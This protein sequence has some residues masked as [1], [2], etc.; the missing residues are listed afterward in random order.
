MF[1]RL[2]T[3]NMPLLLPFYREHH[4]TI[5]DNT[6]GAVYQWRNA[7][8]TYFSIV[9]NMLCIRASYGADGDCYTLPIGSGDLRTA[10]AHCEAEARERNDEFKF[11]VIPKE[12]V[13]ELYKIYGDRVV[14]ENRRGWADY[15]Y[16]AEGFLDYRGKQ[17]HTQ[18]N[19]VNRFFRENPS[20]EVRPV[21]AQL[22]PACMDFLCRYEK[23]HSDMNAIEKNELI[24]AREL[25]LHRNELN[26][27]A[28]CLV[29][30]DAVIAL[31]IGEKRFDTLY[32]HVEKARMDIAGAYPTM[33]QAFIRAHEGITYV[34]REDDAGDEGLRYSKLNYRPI[35]LIDKYFVRIQ[36]SSLSK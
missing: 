16:E 12:G 34:N 35:R 24:G 1:T 21:D 20:A 33:A 2:T 15:L 4:P 32:V 11:C 18:R 19:H 30:G 26:Q 25:L 29:L 10:L 27:S 31:S 6:Q 7:Y 23:E 13:D 14:A 36:P 9:D 22:E 28:F 8:V 5:C 17:Y 3:E